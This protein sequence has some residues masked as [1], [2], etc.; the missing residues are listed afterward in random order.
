MAKRLPFVFVLVLLVAVAVPALAEPRGYEKENLPI[1]Y[2]YGTFDA[3]DNLLLL[4]G[5]PAEAFCADNPESPFDGSPGEAPSRVYVRDDGSVDVKVDDR[6]QPIYLY[7]SGAISEAPGWIAGVCAGEIEPNLI[8]EGTANLKVRDTYLFE[9]GPPTHIFNSVNGKAVAPD[10]T[11]FKVR[12][13]A[14]IPFGDQGPIGVPP[15]WVSL[16]VKEI[17]R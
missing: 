7:A 10:G 8:A 14:D 13:S 15:D 2:F 11:T 3:S 4:A 12:A 5:A 17:K 16:E 6:N 1:G 9:D